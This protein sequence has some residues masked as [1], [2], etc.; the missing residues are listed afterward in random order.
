MRLELAAR[1]WCSARS[2]AESRGSSELIPTHCR[3][4][5][6]HNQS[7]KISFKSLCSIDCSDILV[8]L[9]LS[10]AW[11]ISIPPTLFMLKGEIFMKSKRPIFHQ[12]WT[13]WTL[14]PWFWPFCTIWAGSLQSR[15]LCRWFMDSTSL[16]T[17]GRLIKNVFSIGAYRSRWKRYW[18]RIKSSNNDDNGW[19]ILA[20][21]YVTNS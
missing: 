16:N 8:V 15:W 1:M 2:W 9:I 7:K 3:Q 19:I 14:G 18:N 21:E 13:V 12:G 20:T 5:T 4:S 11:V 10:L 17:W 6:H